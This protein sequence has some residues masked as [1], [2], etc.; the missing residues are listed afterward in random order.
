MLTAKSDTVD[1]VVGLETGAD[2]YIAKPFK[3]KEL[4]AR[5][6]ARMRHVEPPAPEEITVGD[7]AHRR[8]RPQRDAVPVRRSS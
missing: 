5:I 6:R 4:I 1:V 8:R 7:L 2:D 3:P